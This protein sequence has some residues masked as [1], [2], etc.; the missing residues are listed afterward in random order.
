MTPKRGKR[1]WPF[2]GQP[3]SPYSAVQLAALR[4]CIA[5]PTVA[6]AGFNDV[7]RAL[8]SSLLA[9]RTTPTPDEFSEAM[10][11]LYGLL[12]DA[13]MPDGVAV[14][15]DDERQA[16]FRAAKGRLDELYAKARA[17]GLVVE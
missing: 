12:R 7:L 11:G 8:W 4:A 3:T 15:E 9:N 14:V 10:E 5:D 1:R 13:A 16:V 2:P 6:P 17:S